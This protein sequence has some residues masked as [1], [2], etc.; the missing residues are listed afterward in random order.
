MLLSKL[1]Y[2]NLGPFDEIQFEFDEHVNVFIGPNNSGKSTALMALGEITVYPLSLPR[3]LLREAP[4]EFDIEFGPESKSLKGTI[5]LKVEPAIPLLTAIGY[6]SFVPA[7]RR[8]TDF[9]AEG[10]T[11]NKRPDERSTLLRSWR[12]VEREDERVAA[13]PEELQR[14]DKLIQTDALSISDEA[15]VQRIIDLDYRA[16]RRNAPEIRNVL[17]MTTSIV[18]AVPMAT[19]FT[20]FG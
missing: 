2:T 6:S 5:P 17:D 13:L 15:V 4:C 10:P 19:R 3:K 18:S 14:R 20:L 12:T 9:R 8:S 7:I 11:V 16:Y 1:W